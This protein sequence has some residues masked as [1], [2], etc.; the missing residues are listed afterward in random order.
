MRVLVVD[1]G[2]D[3]RFMLRVI[4]EGDGMDVEEAS[5]GE[6]ALRILTDE[7]EFD[8]VVMD[9]RM[10]LMTGLE[11][12]RA[13]REAGTHPP[14]VLFSAYLHPALHAEADELGVLTLGKADVMALPDVLRETLAAA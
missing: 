3:V 10:P 12:A 6:A 8:A 13:L 2:A 9:Q 1:D 14:L 4:L 7:H 11:L 5:S